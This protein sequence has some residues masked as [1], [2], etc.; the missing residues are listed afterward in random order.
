MQFLLFL[1]L[2]FWA[3][4]FSNAGEPIMKTCGNFKTVLKNQNSYKTPFDHPEYGYDL[5]SGA[6]HRSDQPIRA[7]G[8]L[9]VYFGDI[10]KSEWFGGAQILLD[11]NDPDT[12]T[13]EYN[14]SII[15]LGNLILM[16][17][18]FEIHKG[19]P[20][21]ITVGVQTIPATMNGFTT[22]MFSGDP[23]QDFP[24]NMTS[25]LINV[26]AVTIDFHFDEK[27]G[28]GLTYAKG[29]SY[30]SEVGAFLH[31]DSA[32]TMAL[33]ARANWCDIMV[34]G[35]YQYVTGNR[36]ATATV[37]TDNGN[38]FSEFDDNGFE[39]YLFNTTIAWTIP[40]DHFKFTPFAGYQTMKG[41]ETPLPDY[42]DQNSTIQGFHYEPY[43]P[44]KIRGELKTVGIKIE[45]EWLGKTNEFCLEYTDSVMDD[46]S[47]IDGLKKG[48]VDR[49]IQ[50]A[51]DFFYPG[52][53]SLSSLSGKSSAINKFVDIDYLLNTEYSLALNKSTKIG[54]FFYTLKANNDQTI[55]NRNFIEKQ[56]SDRAKI[57]LVTEN[58][59]SNTQADAVVQVIML[60]LNTP[61]NMGEGLTL[62]PLEDILNDTRAAEWT[63]TQSM[64][65]F[66]KYSF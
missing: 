46:M 43:G 42:S 33:W 5:K 63:D 58:G 66:M 21:G 52:Q 15:E 24:A 18:P 13:G 65:I 40:F 19:R 20:F 36:G 1:L 11:A 35:A 64:G 9:N 55:N 7:T 3:H 4:N 10:G 45:N 49:Y 6:S 26:P 44:R 16:Y 38:T 47:G 53:W 59:L 25:G 54:I 32:Q 17:R 23:D 62:T 14:D 41:D 22:F 57:K 28:I 37:E 30:I 39:H 48:A 61:Q 34:S 50:P 56:I 12:D 29:C 60:Y 31:K 8:E 27:T 2:F 51:I